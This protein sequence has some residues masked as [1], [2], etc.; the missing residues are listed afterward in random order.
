MQSVKQ[1]LQRYFTNAQVA[2]LGAVEA[3]LQSLAS[4]YFR[5][6]FESGNEQILPTLTNSYHRQNHS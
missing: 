2:L 3:T 4:P 6:Y 1:T 5:G